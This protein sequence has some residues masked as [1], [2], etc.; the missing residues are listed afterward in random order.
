MT[1]AVVTFIFT[2]GWVSTL[3]FEIEHNMGDLISTLFDLCFS[4]FLVERNSVLREKCL[5]FYREKRDAKNLQ[6]IVCMAMQCRGNLF[7]D[8]IN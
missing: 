1:L 8:Y 5:H 7:D 2:H 4:A 3:C 6:Y